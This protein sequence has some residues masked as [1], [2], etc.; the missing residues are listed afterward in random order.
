MNLNQD[1]SHQNNGYQDENYQVSL[2]RNGRVD[3]EKE[4]TNNDADISSAV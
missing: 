3:H 1:N 2:E 4:N